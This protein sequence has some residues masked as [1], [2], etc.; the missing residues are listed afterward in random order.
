MLNLLREKD[1]HA[2]LAMIWNDTEI[3]PYDITEKAIKGGYC[4]S[5]RA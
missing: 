4:K 5:V 2:D 1:V 3:K